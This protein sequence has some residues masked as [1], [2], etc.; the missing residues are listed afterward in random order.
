MGPL[1][2]GFSAVRIF[3]SDLGRA[4]DFYRN[5]LGLHLT[6]EESVYAVFQLSNVTVLV[7]RVDP[8][9][10]EFKELVGRFT[11]VS[12]STG[13]IYAAYD[14]LSAL[15]VRFEGPPEKQFWGGTLAHFHDPDDN[16]V[17][18]VQGL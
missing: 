13:D 15:G 6:H 12:F 7:E 17:T 2:T 5:T 4:V 10:T 16:V 18:L 9:D 11:A 8:G 1:I 14:R 3:V